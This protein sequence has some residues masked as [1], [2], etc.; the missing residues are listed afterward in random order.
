MLLLS[1]NAID[2]VIVW[3]RHEIGFGVLLLLQVFFVPPGWSLGVLPGFMLLG[4]GIYGGVFRKWRTEPGLWMLAL[5]LFLL[6]GLCY[7]YFAILNIRWPLGNVQPTAWQRSKV[8]LEVAAG[9]AL[10]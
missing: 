2:R 1:E 7:A 9:L 4:L 5:F 10:F 8:A 3:Y 6:L